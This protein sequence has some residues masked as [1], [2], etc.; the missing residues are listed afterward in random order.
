MAGGRDEEGLKDDLD[1]GDFDDLDE[2]DED[3]GFDGAEVR[4]EYDELDFELFEEEEFGL[5]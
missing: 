5:R 3:L 1:G 2:E 4:R